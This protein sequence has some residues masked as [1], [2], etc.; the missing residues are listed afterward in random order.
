[1]W[2]LYIRALERRQAGAFDNANRDA[3]RYAVARSK[4]KIDK[5]QHTGGSAIAPPP[6]TILNRYAIPYAIIMAYT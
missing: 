3:K 4:T 1:M 2:K 6:A 5:T